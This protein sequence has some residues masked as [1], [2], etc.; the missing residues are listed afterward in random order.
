MVD[1]HTLKDE[2]G[3]KALCK[4]VIIHKWRKNVTWAQNHELLVAEWDILGSQWNLLSRTERAHFSKSKWQCSYQTQWLIFQLWSLSCW[5]C[6]FQSL[7]VNMYSSFKYKLS[8]Y[9]RE[10]FLKNIILFC[11]NKL[12]CAFK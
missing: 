6:F 9:A 3:G 1:T 4:K 10:L 2:S 12:Y 5:K 8:F 11:S 7:P